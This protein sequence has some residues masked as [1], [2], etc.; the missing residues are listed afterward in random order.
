MSGTG[1]TKRKSSDSGEGI[2]DLKKIKIEADVS[3]VIFW[4]KKLLFG[5]R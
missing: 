2:S 5:V 3:K 1:G 4:K